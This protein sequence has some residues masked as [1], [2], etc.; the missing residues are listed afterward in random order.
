MLKRFFSIFRSLYRDIKFLAFVVIGSTKAKL[1]FYKQKV[2]KLEIGAGA[3]EKKKDFITSDLSIKADY[4]FDFRLGLPFP[5]ESLD[6]IYSEHVFEHFQ[7]RELVSLL[8]DCYRSLK[9]NG[10]LSLV[11]P[12]ARIFLNAYFHPDEFD[13]KKYCQYDFGLSYKCRIDYVNYVFYMDGQH[14]YMFDDEN[15][16]VLLRD[17]GFR[18]VQLRDFDPSMDQEARQNISIYV[19]ARK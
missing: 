4:P 12:D 18:D 14:Q 19:E 11:V 17:M 10:V 13:Y 15:I 9:P 3:S 6:L 8:S 7:Y 5:N 2:N 16:L 1:F